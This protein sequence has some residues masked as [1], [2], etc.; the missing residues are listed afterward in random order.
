MYQQRQEQFASVNVTDRIF[1]QDG[2]VYMKMDDTHQLN[3]TCV[4]V[5]SNPI[6]TFITQFTP[7]F[8]CLLHTFMVADAQQ[9]FLVGN[10]VAQII[11]LLFGLHANAISLSTA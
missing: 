9:V 8:L 10:F 7:L 2:Q 4:R 1:V 6:S 11:H 3:P 5:V